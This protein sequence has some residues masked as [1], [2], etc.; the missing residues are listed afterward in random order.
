MTSPVMSKF[1]VQL[2]LWLCFALPTQVSTFN[3]L[4]V[5]SETLKISVIIECELFQVSFKFW[6]IQLIITFFNFV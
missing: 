6:H 2:S 1:D 3:F 4:S 5:N